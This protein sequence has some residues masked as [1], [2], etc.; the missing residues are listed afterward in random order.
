MLSHLTKI[1][2]FIQNRNTEDHQYFSDLFE[3]KIDIDDYL[4]PGSA[5]IW[6]GVKRKVAGKGKKRNYDP[7]QRGILDGN[8]FPRHIWCRLLGNKGYS[9]PAWKE[10]GLNEFELAHIFS[11]KIDDCELDMESFDDVVGP[12]T[13]GMFSCAANA[14]LLPKGSVRPTDTS[15]TIKR[16]FFARYIELYGEELLL[17]FSQFKWDLVPSWYGSLRWNEPLIT[18]NWEANILGMLDNRNTAIEKILALAE[19]M[20][21]HRL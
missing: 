11:H 18:E 12:A 4:F 16:I 10:L 5:C 14:V 6:P 8:E 19:S 1:V 9:G 15:I 2:S 17:N 21:E 7:K 13:S 20:P 3:G